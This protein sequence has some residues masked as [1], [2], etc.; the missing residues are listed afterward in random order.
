MKKIYSLVLI[1][2]ALLVGTNAWAQNVAK[3]GETEYATVAEAIAAAD[4]GATITLLADAGG[5]VT[6]SK[7]ITLNGDKK[8][9]GNITIGASEVTLTLAGVTIDVTGNDAIVHLGK[10][11]N[12]VVAEGTTNVINAK[13]SGCDCFYG[14]NNGCLNISGNGTL[15]VYGNEAIHV[16][17]LNLSAPNATYGASKTLMYEPHIV[18]ATISAGT[19]DREFPDSYVT[20]PL[21]I[22]K[23][24]SSYV[25]SNI[26]ANK[27]VYN[28]TAYATL[29]AA[30][31][32]AP[33]GSTIVM[34]ADDNSSVE[35]GKNLIIDTKGHSIN[36]AVAASGYAKAIMGDKVAFTD[37]AIAAFLMADGTAS[38]TI[39]ENADISNAGTIHVRGNKTLTI[40]EGVTVTYKRQG[41]LANIVVD[42]GAKLTM[43]GSGTCRPTASECAW[44]SY[45]GCRLVDNN[46]TLVIGVLN[47]ANNCLKLYSTTLRRGSI[48]STNADATTTIN[49]VE[50]FAAMAATWNSGGNFTINGG[51]FISVSHVENGYN[52]GWYSY[53]L[54]NDEGGHTTIN[55]GYFQGSHGCFDADDE[56]TVDITG[57][58]F[59]APYGLDLT[60]YTGD[61]MWN[62]WEATGTIRHNFYAF[63]IATGA[64]ANVSGGD[65]WSETPNANSNSVIALCG[66]NDAYNYYGIVNLYGG[67]WQDKV[68]VQAR[69]NGDSYYPSS[70]PTT[71]AWYSAFNTYAPLPAGYEYYET[72]DATYPYGVRAIEGKEADAIDPA[73]QAAQEA[74]PTYTIPWQQATTWEAEVVPVANTIVT[75]PVGATVTVSND[76]TNK[77]AVAD[78]VYVAQDATLVVEEGTTLTIGEGGVNIG[79]G[80]QLVVEPNAIVTIGAAGVIT[81]E[82]EALVLTSTEDEQA[83]LLYDP[84][85]AENTQPKATVKLTTKSKMLAGDPDW[86]YTYQRFAIPVREAVVPTN[87]FDPA[88]HEY[89]DATEESYG[90]ENYVWEWT[91]NAWATTTWTALEPFKGYQLANN[92]KNGGVTYT[93]SGNLIGNE[94]GQYHFGDLGFDYF[95]NSYTAAIDV[96]TVV[97]HFAPDVEATVWLYDYTNGSN[98]VPVTREDFSDFPPADPFKQIK[99]MEGFLLRSTT[100]TTPAV[101]NYQDA[102]WNNPTYA[103]LRG[104]VPAP[105]RAI[106]NDINNCAIVTI[107]ENGGKYDMVKLVEKD[108]LT[109]EFDNGADAS[110]YME[111]EGVSLYAETT[112]GQLSRVGTNNLNNT[113]L[114]FRSGDNTNYTMQLSN[115]IGN[116]YAIRDNVTGA[117]IYV[118]DDA[119]YN[120]DQDANTTVPA[121]FEIVAINRI[122]TG[123]DNVE[124]VSDEMAIYTVTGQY[125]GRDFSI[126]PAG[127]YVVNGV[128]IIK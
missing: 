90:F 86:Q 26:G 97:N 99:S 69:K 124:Q 102:I 4:N 31:N 27:A 53:T 110:K 125:V 7:D 67:R 122:M 6:L 36:G 56:A 20:A 3:I 14:I 44:D 113:L 29:Q 80:G 64:V 50:I 78:Q 107:R 127:I 62:A 77:N 30:V 81:T 63:Y 61:N 54:R 83:V 106:S 11:L 34:Y 15:N 45:N 117:V 22:E 17:R 41:D 112:I 109:D 79:N 42:N 71:S 98:W 89:Y 16:S 126:L 121:R 101:I 73:Q 2:A 28:Y 91:G 59:H 52:T 128:K 5:N 38:L 35:V 25:V 66:N 48:I 70:V 40:N 74:D 85:V 37:N 72:G 43:L 10:T 75:I 12:V 76:E 19:F 114:S 103:S 49:N 120:F 23:V 32:A 33:A 51:R 93:F 55:G 46:G 8:F 115:V 104:A 58:T 24:S 119:T 39:D 116:E 105:R 94:D 95:G 84:T 100:G 18:S 65:F 1:A 96:E 21:F 123:I 82:D 88:I 13:S 111:Q 68:K 87:D 47:D 9:A 60:Q 108:Y 57:G 118:A 92:S